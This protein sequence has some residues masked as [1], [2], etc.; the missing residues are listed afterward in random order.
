MLIFLY[1]QDAYS[2][3]EEMRRII[4][5]CEKACLANGWASLNWFNFVRIDAKEKEMEIFKQIRQTVNTTSMF[6]EKKLIILENIFFAPIETQNEILDFLK[7]KNLQKDSETTIVF[8]S[9]EIESKNELF[10]FLKT[11]AKCQK[12]DPLKGTQLKNWIKNRV[13]ENNGNIDN[14]AIEKLIEYAGDDLW[15]MFNEINKLL[16]HDKKI[17]IADIELLIKPEIDLNVFEIIDAIGL[18]NKN[19]ALK[20]MGDYFEKGEDEIRLLGMFV[21]QFRN[22]IKVKSA[23]NE[24]LGLHPFVLRKTEAQARNFS[25]EELKKIYYQLLTID[26]NIKLGKVNS[27]AAL[28]LFVTNL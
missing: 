21:Y 27:V 19:R 22:L 20:L 2:S 11:T 28:E 12:F 5:E 1:G 13:S 17:S 3:R 10:E 26:F 16:S 23:P 14:Q 4:A 8:W 7:N 15:R 25:F 9:E 6:S 18:K 24:N